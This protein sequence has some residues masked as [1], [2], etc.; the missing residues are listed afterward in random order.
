M[1]VT[2]PLVSCGSSEDGGGAGPPAGV[3]GSSVASPTTVAKKPTGS[4]RWETVT[5]FKG[6]GA[7]DAPAFEILP[8]AIQWRVRWRCE[9]GTL[10]MKTDPPPRRPAP[11]VDSPC[12]Q[13]GEGFA[14][15][16]GK[17]RLAVEASGPW[18]LTIDQQ[19]D[20]ALD[21][22]LL[23]GMEQATVVGQGA[24]YNVE[25]SGKGTAK[26]YLMTDGSRVVRFEGFETPPNTD[27][28]VWL[29]EAAT[30]RTSADA[31]GSPRRVLGN[32][33]S[34]LGTMNYPVPADLATA[35]IKSVVIW[36]EPVAIAYTAAPLARA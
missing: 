26:L 13:K 25:M 7:S 2:G 30:P 24:F 6:T 27:L 16:T 36:C 28:F 11:I 29:S 34:T 10:R 8:E 33:K 23:P 12:P 32:V 19:V 17:V 3:P 14:I 18:E 5:T 22:P 31:T 1:L 21:E 9:S 4:P 35:Q 15:S 20:T